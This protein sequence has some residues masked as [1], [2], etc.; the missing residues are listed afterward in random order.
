[1]I[2]VTT[3]FQLTN[4]NAVYLLRLMEETIRKNN[5]QYFTDTSADAIGMIVAE[6]EKAQA[7]I[8]ELEAELDYLNEYIDERIAGE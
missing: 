4:K 7:R 5:V 6:Y 8:A 2:T 1:M 3:N